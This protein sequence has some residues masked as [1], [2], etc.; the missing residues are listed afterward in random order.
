LRRGT[1]DATYGE[2]YAFDNI[3]RTLRRVD[4]YEG[5]SPSDPQPHRFRR[6]ETRVALRSGRWE[7]TWVYEFTGPTR[8]R[9]LIE[10]GDYIQYLR[11]GR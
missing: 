7:R 3:D 2:L 1:C 11:T 8:D 9:K 4:E 5:S 6:V 10:S